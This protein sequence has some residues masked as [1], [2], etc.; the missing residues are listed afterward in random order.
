MLSRFPLQYWLI[1]QKFDYVFQGFEPTFREGDIQVV[2]SFT[3]THYRER[4]FL[5]SFNNN[6]F[7]SV[8][9]VEHQSNDERIESV[10]YLIST[11]LDECIETHSMLD[12]NFRKSQFINFGELLALIFFNFAFIG[13][14]WKELQT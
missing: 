7:L 1:F 8:Q 11:M 6:C 14:W 5:F 3:S 9:I 13:F 10:L 2:F 12:I 4:T